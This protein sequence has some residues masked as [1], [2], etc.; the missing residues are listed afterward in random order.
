MERTREGEDAFERE[1][2]RGAAER[3]KKG[4]T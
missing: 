2:E 1:D 3:F 4:A